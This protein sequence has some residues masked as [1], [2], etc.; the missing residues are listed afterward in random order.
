MG[1]LAQEKS[2]E[3]FLVI[4]HEAVQMGMPKLLACCEHHIACNPSDW[5]EG[6]VVAKRLSK[7]LSGCSALRIAAGLQKA[8]LFVLSDTNAIRGDR[9]ECKCCVGRRE[10]RQWHS[11][12]YCKCNLEMAIGWGTLSHIVRANLRKHVP[13][14][15]EFLRMADSN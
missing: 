2:S 1:I 9:C 5:L 3:H 14:P 11:N 12:Q 4:V 15:A 10:D 6:S 7:I 13:A 8:Y